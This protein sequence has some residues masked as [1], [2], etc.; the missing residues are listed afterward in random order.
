[1]KVWSAIFNLI[2]VVIIAIMLI[3]I[4]NIENTNRRQFEELR[5]AQAVDYAVEAAFRSAVSADSVGTDY[6]NN[7]LNNI[8]LNHSKVLEIFSNM[9]CLSYDMSSSEENLKNIED[10]IPTAALCAIDGYY[11][12]EE[13]EKDDDTETVEGK[14]VVGEDYGLLWGPKRPYLL[15]LDISDDDDKAVLSLS[16]INDGFTAVYRNS[17]V[18]PNIMEL[19]SYPNPDEANK[20]LGTM[21]IT[22]PTDEEFKRLKRQAISQC[23]TEDMNY[24]IHTRNIQRTKN[25]LN[26]FYMP[27]S[28]TAQTTINSIESPSLI[29]MFQDSSFLNGYDIDVVSVSGYRVKM[30]SF[31]I[32]FTQNGVKYYC[33]AGQQKDKNGNYVNVNV[34]RKFDSFQEAASA[35][36]NPHYQF[37]ANGTQT[38]YIDDDE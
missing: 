15:T 16:L 21:G 31:I 18:A 20:V 12:L 11:I 25:K 26:A 4:N 3:V 29:L 37:L 17:S 8:H 35:G 23:L 32:G 38:K 22:V 24:A 10:C 34:D 19:D 27:S 6:A 5:L 36:Y 9:L 1:M 2:A 13:V 14:K 30:K 33:Y 28:S 7:G